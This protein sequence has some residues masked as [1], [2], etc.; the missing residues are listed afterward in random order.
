MEKILAFF[1]P[2][3][4]ISSLFSSLSGGGGVTYKLLLDSSKSPILFKL[5]KF[6]LLTL[7]KGDNSF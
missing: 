1:I 6:R 3:F 7:L 4:F 5:L 2:S